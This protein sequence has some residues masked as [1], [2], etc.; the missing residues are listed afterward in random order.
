VPYR[1]T[2]SP[3]R[4]IAIVARLATVWIVFGST[5]FSISLTVH[6]MPPLISSGLRFL[7]AALILGLILIFSGNVRAIKIPLR[8]VVT[9]MI[10]G[11]I[12]MGITI[13]VVVLAE[14]HVPS[15]LVAIT[16][17]LVPVWVV[18][19]RLRASERIS[20]LTILGVTLGFVGIF[21]AV[22]GGG[23]LANTGQQATIGL[24]LLAI[25][26]TTVL[27]ANFSWRTPHLNLPK[28]ALASTSFQMLGAAIVLPLA[29]LSLGERI[30]MGQITPTAF[31]AWIYLVLASA[32]GYAAYNWMCTHT[33]ASTASSYSYASP[34]IALGLGVWL[35]G[36]T[37]T[38]TMVLGMLVAVV[39]VALLTRGE[40]S[41]KR[42]HLPRRHLA[43]ARPRQ[44]LRQGLRQGPRHASH[45]RDEG[46]STAGVRH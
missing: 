42:H 24:W 13:G 12:V 21:A 40:G 34:V 6:S 38:V 20:Q 7:G 1:Y 4:P 3:Q 15:A 31:G 41:R 30:V 19:F 8:Q 32:A 26:G 37:L 16:M 44:G 39:G 2:R 25:V 33:T 23:F 14:R 9:A 45:P 46:V 35:G 28:N 43:R 36:E 29:G 27:W 10:S 17:A 18:I 5:Y 22:L 11:A